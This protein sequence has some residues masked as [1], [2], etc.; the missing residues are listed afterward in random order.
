MCWRSMEGVAGGDG[1]LRCG[2]ASKDGELGRKWQHYVEVLF[3]E[4]RC[5][6]SCR[7]P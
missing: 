3:W 6:S 2:V 4:C 7:S 5:V 1:E